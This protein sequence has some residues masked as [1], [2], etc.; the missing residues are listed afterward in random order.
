MRVSGLIVSPL[1]E[2]IRSAATQRSP[3]CAK[4]F[5]AGTA[6]FVLSVLLHAGGVGGALWFLAFEAPPPSETILEPMDLVPANEEAFGPTLVDPAPLSEAE[7]A[8]NAAPEPASTAD[9]PEPTALVPPESVSVIRFPPAPRPSVRPC[10]PDKTHR[11]PPLSGKATE[12]PVIRERF[13][14]P[15]TTR[16]DGGGIIPAPAI[17]QPSPTMGTHE[18]GR[19]EID[20]DIIRKRA[21]RERRPDLQDTAP[22]RSGPTPVVPPVLPVERPPAIDSLR[23]RLL[24]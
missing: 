10:R 2:G 21:R 5:A 8:P 7:D 3:R 20:E 23:N 17:E 16:L 9:P 15:D 4:R 12:T 14:L 1:A 24:R 11:C 13:R 22:I 6:G 18:N 19:Y